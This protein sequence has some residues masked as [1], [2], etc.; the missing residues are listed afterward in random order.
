MSLIDIAKKE[1]RKLAFD[2][3]KTSGQL[4]SLLTDAEIMEVVDDQIAMGLHDDEIN[5]RT[6]ELEREAARVYDEPADLMGI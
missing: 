1:I 2:S 6:Q 5:D 3:Y 4:D